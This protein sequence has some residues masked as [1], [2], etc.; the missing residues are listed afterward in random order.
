MTDPRHHGFRAP[1]GADGEHRAPTLR[2]RLG[3]VLAILGPLL[4]VGFAVLLS[5]EIGGGDR[6]SFQAPKDPGP[7]HVHALGINPADGALFVATHTG[8]YRIAERRRKAERVGDGY[9]DTMGFTVA[10]PNRFLGSGHP[11]INTARAQELPS[12][13]GLI[14][15]RDAGRSWE[16]VSLSGEADFHVLRFAGARVYGFDASHGRL[17]VSGD[18]GRSW[19]EVTAPGAIVDLAVHP[20]DL[21]RL[22]TTV[23]GSGAGLFESRNAGRTWRR[24]GGAV[25]L[26]AWPRGS[27]LYLVDARGRVFSSASA[28]ATFRA[29]GR[30]GGSPAA[31]LAHTPLELFAAL[32]DGTVVRS[33]DGGGT[34]RVRSRP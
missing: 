23:G 7:F 21:S 16:A 19:R 5:R 12:S 11:D 15:S 31:L 10:G 6:F 20:S 22:L 17:M 13:L 3:L 34:W 25:G 1:S 8:L 29:R 2:S 24:V 9:Q 33:G 14:E 4:A 28:G 30:L 18:R 32:H 27:L 26:L